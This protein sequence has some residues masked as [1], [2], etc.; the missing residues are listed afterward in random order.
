VYEKTSPHVKQATG[1]VV[2]AKAVYKRSLATRVLTDIAMTASRGPPP[3]PAFVSRGSRPLGYRVA[4]AGFDE[5]TSVACP[6]GSES[7]ISGPEGERRV[8]F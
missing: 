8:E 6:H 2:L 4:K 1:A 5:R 3:K 7:P